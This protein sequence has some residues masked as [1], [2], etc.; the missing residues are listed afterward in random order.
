MGCLSS[1]WKKKVLEILME[2]Q[3]DTSTSTLSTFTTKISLITMPASRQ[4]E[5]MVKMQEMVELVE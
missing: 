3:V 4:W 1:S 2:A 5:D